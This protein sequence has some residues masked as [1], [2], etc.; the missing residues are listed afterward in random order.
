MSFNH[1]TFPALMYFTSA[2]AYHSDTKVISR[3]DERL[4][5]FERLL[6]VFYSCLNEK[7]VSDTS[8]PH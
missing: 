5:L 6:E 8:L 3:N 2:T 1:P 7:R 4:T